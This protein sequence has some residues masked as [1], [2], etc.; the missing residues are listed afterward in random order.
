MELRSRLGPGRLVLAK[1]ESK[2]GNMRR[3]DLV[4]KGALLFLLCALAVIGANA[5]AQPAPAE[6]AEGGDRP[7]NGRTLSGDPL[8]GEY[9]VRQSSPT[10]ATTPQPVA[11]G[12]EREPAKVPGPQGASPLGVWRR[13]VESGSVEFRIEKDH[14]WAVIIREDGKRKL[15]V[16]FRADYAISKDGVLFGLV[17][18]A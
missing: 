11:V 10:G 6:T 2:E 16:D 3:F 12:R 1:H 7:A 17:T 18:S 13:S 5:W 15:K 9:P 8:V 14:L 4:L